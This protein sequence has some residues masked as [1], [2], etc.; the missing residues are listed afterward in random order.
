MELT[1]CRSDG[2]C[3]GNGGTLYITP[4]DE[5]TTTWTSS[6][7]SFCSSNGSQTIPVGSDS[8]SGSNVNVTEPAAGTSGT[9]GLACGNNGIP[10]VQE[11]FT[12][13]YPDV[14]LDYNPVPPIVPHEGMP[15]NNPAT[16]TP[17]ISGFNDALC[18]ITGAN[19]GETNSSVA[20]MR[21]DGRIDGTGAYAVTL[22]VEGESAYT[23]TCYYDQNADGAADSTPP[24]S[25]SVIFRRLPEIQ[26]T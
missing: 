11:S 23:V 14:S 22:N 26:E 25:D 7:V 2:T 8:R 6:D 9:Y 1:G 13:V 17:I 16:I 4:T 19:V 10:A 12:V 20:A 5:V 15:P 3:V 24:M 21:G 18:Y